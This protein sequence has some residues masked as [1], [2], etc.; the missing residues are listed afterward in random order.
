MRLEPVSRGT[1]PDPKGTE[2][3]GQ[4][5]NCQRSEMHWNSVA[6]VSQ[7]LAPIRSW[8][9]PRARFSGAVAVRPRQGEEP[10]N[11]ARASKTGSSSPGKKDKLP[12]QE[13]R[14]VKL[15][16][17]AAGVHDGFSITSRQE[18]PACSLRNPF[19]ITVDVGP[20]V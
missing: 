19:P 5:A 14:A 17:R 10:P 2:H 8:R 9:H 12:K 4:P 18:E 13:T 6:K 3:L 15:V 20:C 1:G 16:S 7:R 11:L